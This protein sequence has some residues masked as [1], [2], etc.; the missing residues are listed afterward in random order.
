MNILGRSAH[1]HWDE[2]GTMA[3]GGNIIPSSNIVDLLNDVLRDRRSSA[4][5]IW[6]TFA[7]L[8]AF[9]NVPREFI[10]NSQRWEY[11]RRLHGMQGDKRRPSD[12][13]QYNSKRR[14]IKQPDQYYPPN[15]DD[16]DDSDDDDDD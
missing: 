11:I 15:D 7:K 14:R 1:I 16:D 5:I 6:E 4:P 3:I 12:S 8:L 13:L 10:H 2:R 9:L